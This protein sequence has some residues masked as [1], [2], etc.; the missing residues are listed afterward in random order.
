MKPFFFPAAFCAIVFAGCQSESKPA[1]VKSDT[2]VSKEPIIYPFTPKY[3]L[4]WQP[5]DEKN[6]LMVLNCLK[7]YVDGDLKGALTD[8]ADTVV[9]YSDGFH[10]QG[11]KDSLGTII[12]AERKEL[13]S[14][15]KNFDT[16]ATLYYPD[17]DD[18]WVT[19]WYTET[20]TD[21]KGKTDSLNYVDDV[22][23]K[24]GKIREYDEKVR[25]FPPPPV[26][27]K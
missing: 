11:S 20:W 16:W 10:F 22:L 8:F 18:T 2:A 15:S 25:H 3:S 4:N 12:A 27:K 7:H 5:G 9:F 6:A 17:K 14:V 26:A 1:V 24:N 19:L 21:K 13:A 23:I